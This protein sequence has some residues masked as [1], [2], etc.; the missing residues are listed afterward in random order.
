MEPNSTQKISKKT[1]LYPAANFIRFFALPFTL[2][3]CYGAY[4]KLATTNM[5]LSIDH[6]GTIITGILLTL[7]P[8]LMNRFMPVFLLGTGTF[9]VV[10]L[11]QPD[12]KS[13]LNLVLFIALTLLLFKPYKIYIRI[14]IQLFC[15]AVICGCLWYV[16]QEFYKGIE[17]FVVTGKLTDSFLS[18][19]IKTY[20]PGDFSYY[21]A[22]TFFVLSIRQYIPLKQKNAPDIDNHDNNRGHSG[23]RNDLWGF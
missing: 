18:N 5:S 9:T 15:I 7:S 1:N 3:L 11:L 22:V 12:T 4:D 23:G 8:F 21:A 10:N 16:Y 6:W 20:L 2:L 14:I 13:W 19:R 17:H